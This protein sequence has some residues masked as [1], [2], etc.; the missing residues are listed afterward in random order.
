MKHILYLFLIVITFLSCSKKQDKQTITETKPV[1]EKIF[2][3]DSVVYEIVNTV[4]ELPEF[5]KDSTKYMLNTGNIFI[6][7]PS[8]IDEGLYRYIYKN[9]AKFDSIA[10]DNQILKSRDSYYKQ[11]FIKSHQLIDFDLTTP[12]TR[13]QFDSLRNI[14]KKNYRY[15]ITVSLPFFVNDSIVFISYANPRIQEEF[16][17]K[18]INGKWMRY[19]NYSIEYKL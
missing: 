17:M 6:A 4:L 1:K 16:F 7:P 8:I 12:R 14:I 11:E 2:I 5:K 10:F 15:H 3:T 13:Q 19:E 18:K 9:F